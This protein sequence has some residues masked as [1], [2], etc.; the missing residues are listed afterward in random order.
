MFNKVIDRT[1][2]IVRHKG[3]DFKYKKEL[4]VKQAMDLAYQ[5]CLANEIHKDSME[6][7]VA[8]D[9]TKI[10]MMKMNPKKDLEVYNPSYQSF[11]VEKVRAFV[12]RGKMKFHTRK[13]YWRRHP[14]EDRLI[15]VSGTFVNKELSGYDDTTMSNLIKAMETYNKIILDDIHTGKY[16][17]GVEM[18]TFAEIMAA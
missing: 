16:G 17:V 6:D 12:N 18:M 3:I 9:P 8:V 10:V 1:T 13:A 2:V 5:A 11:D 7:W 15:I 4:N 14:K